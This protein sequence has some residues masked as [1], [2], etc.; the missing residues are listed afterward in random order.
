MSKLKHFEF[1]NENY[2][3]KCEQCPKEPLINGKKHDEIPVW[4][5]NHHK[6]TGHNEVHVSQFVTAKIKKIHNTG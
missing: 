3:L 4:I 6:E 5:L 1:S 2:S